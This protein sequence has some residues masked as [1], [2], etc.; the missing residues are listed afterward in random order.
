MAG[1]A[2]DQSKLT[3]K[4]SKKTNAM[5]NVDKIHSDLI[6]SL[7]SIYKQNYKIRERGEVIYI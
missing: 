1:I 6:N 7:I 5:L 2:S 3:L 4:L